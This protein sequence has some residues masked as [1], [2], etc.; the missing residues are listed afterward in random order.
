[1]KSFLF[2]RLLLWLLV[3]AA[4]T[5][6]NAQSADPSAETPQAKRVFLVTVWPGEAAYEKFGHNFILIRDPA[7]SLGGTGETT[8]YGFNWGV[9]DFEQKNFF[10]NFIQ[11]R[12]KYQFAVENAAAA[13]DYYRQQNRRILLQELNL[14]PEQ[15][16]RLWELLQENLRPENREYRYDYFRDNCSTRL[17]D[18]L[19]KA[20]DGQLSQAMQGA[21][22][23][24]RSIRWHVNRYSADSL[25]LHAV[26]NYMLGPS[27]DEPIDAWQSAF[28]PME[29]SAAV[30][31]IPGL[32]KAEGEL[33]PTLE[34][35]IT[36]W[37]VDGGYSPDNRRLYFYAA[38]AAVVV[39]VLAGQTRW[40]R[41]PARVAAIGLLAVVCVAWLVL[42]WAAA[43][44][45]HADAQWNQN[46][47]LPVPV[48]V[49]FVLRYCLRRFWGWS[50]TKALLVGVFAG[51]LVAGVVPVMHAGLNLSFVTLAVAALALTPPP[52]AKPT[53]LS[54]QS[55]TV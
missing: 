31:G 38:M 35:S 21:P 44:T 7:G 43:F 6:A 40:G 47:W 51:L 10:W 16:A 24:G 52:L 23:G 48:F 42:V 11:G 33:G 17:R 27:I 9:F 1:M 29:L 8:D 18:M 20:L 19:D 2:S 14:T 12:M 37:L 30:G 34:K 25:W 4:G 41:I 32:V 15:T 36:P 46:L 28:I 13:V 54:R 45:D 55:E 50:K 5:Q 53:P 22:A 49:M 39:L 26:L 3:L